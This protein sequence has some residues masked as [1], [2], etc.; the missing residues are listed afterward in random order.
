[1]SILSS[2]DQKPTAQLQPKERLLFVGQI[3]IS[4]VLLGW[5]LH[6]AQSK[7][8]WS[9]LEQ[10]SLFW[11]VVA[12]ALKSISLLLRELRLWLALP[13]P[14]P[15]LLPI[16][17]IGLF[18]GAL[19]TFLPARGGDI[20]AIALLVK[21]SSLSTAKAAFAVAISALFE[22]LV[23]GILV[24]LGLYWHKDLFVNPEFLSN[25]VQWVSTSTVLGV[26]VFLVLGAIGKRYFTEPE[27]DSLPP[28]QHILS[29]LFHL[30]GK[31]ITNMM[32]LII[33]VL[34]TFLDVWLMIVAFALGFEVLGID[35]EATWTISA[36]ILGCSAMLAF[37]L[38]PS[39]GAGPAAAAIFVLSLFGIDESSAVAYS[40][41][42]WILSQ[43]PA[44][45]FGVPALFFIRRKNPD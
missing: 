7:Q 4:M 9:H 45:I 8:V 20:V 40:A 15:P 17:N 5:M 12:L 42:W 18:T 25:A 2:E 34:I 30:T 16:M 1:M 10:L 11:L 13:S 31:S 35:L 41:I 3:A 44:L 27:T 23:F 21:S 32:Y 28:I 38:P 36:L 6:N 24:L 43:I 26:T 33:N 37:L 19:H 14:R 22:A 39:Y 29:E